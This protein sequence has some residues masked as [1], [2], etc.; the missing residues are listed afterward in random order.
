MRQFGSTTHTPALCRDCEGTGFLVIP[1]DHI[2]HGRY[3]DNTREICNT[4]EGSGMVTVTR[5]VH[6]TITP[7][8]VIPEVCPAT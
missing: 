5:T 6:V 1:G 8:P 3:N 4:C 7:K 2:G